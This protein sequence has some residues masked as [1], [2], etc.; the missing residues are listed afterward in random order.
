MT[1]R[2]PCPIC[3]RHF[4]PG[5]AHRIDG[6]KRVYHQDCLPDADSDQIAFLGV[7][8][9][10][11]AVH[12]KRPGIK[13]YLSFVDDRHTDTDATVFG[14]AEAAIEHARSVAKMS[15]HNNAEYEECTWTPTLF[16]ATYSYEGDSVWVLEKE[17]QG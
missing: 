14:T 16:S 1:R 8:T 2:P 7:A 13:V 11:D 15:A 9:D 4:S 12:E 17:V 5:E 10:W 6:N 3:K